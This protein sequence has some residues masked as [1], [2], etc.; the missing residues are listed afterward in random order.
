MLIWG[1]F[2]HKQPIRK[3]D[4]DMYPRLAQHYQVR[5]Y[6]FRPYLARPYPAR[7]KLAQHRVHR[8]WLHLRLIY[9]SLRA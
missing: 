1:L 7:P 4:S 2:A 8:S 5:R 3:R 6:L 9:R